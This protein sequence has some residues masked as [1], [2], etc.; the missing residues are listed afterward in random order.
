MLCLADYMYGAAFHYFTV[1]LV[2]PKLDPQALQTSFH[3]LRQ[4]FPLS[5]QL[6]FVDKYLIQPH[7]QN[8]SADVII[9]VIQQ[10]MMVVDAHHTKIDGTLLVNIFFVWSKLYT[11]SEKIAISP[12]LPFTSFSMI[13]SSIIQSLKTKY[14][15]SNYV[16]ACTVWSYYMARGTKK[17]FGHVISF[18]SNHQKN[19]IGNF[20]TVG[21]V[22]L[23]DTFYESCASLKEMIQTK[24]TLQ[25]NRTFE[26]FQTMLNYWKC[27]FLFDSWL[28]FKHVSFDGTPSGIYHKNF[29]VSQTEFLGIVGMHE[30]NYY[31]SSLLDEGS[32][33]FSD[34]LKKL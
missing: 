13:P 6:C 24:K 18:R 12:T 29:L 1:V 28:S 9:T 7:R 8:Y 4:E 10:N 11:S 5:F 14:P 30:K 26:V 3:K 17:K 19:E 23:C 27:D 20:I 34:F 32:T 16:I 15:F 22:Q 33:R 2:F 21:I 31:L 25:P